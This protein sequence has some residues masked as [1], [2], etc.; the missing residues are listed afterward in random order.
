[1]TTHNRTSVACAVIDSLIKNLKYPKLKWCISDDRSE[2]GHVEA[3]TKQF[4]L[5]GIDDVVVTRTNGAKYG[6]GA[7]LNNGLKYAWNNSDIV[8]TTEDDWYIEKDLDIINDVR[9]LLSN[10]DICMIR[11]GTLFVDN[12]KNK[13]WYVN[14]SQYNS[15]FDYVYSRSKN[16]TKMIFNNPIGLRHKRIY[17][18][19]GYYPENVEPDVVERVIS[20]RYNDLTTYG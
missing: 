2:S 17:D 15:L 16:S 7:S 6:L 3:L 10:P 20:D 8:L 19:I 13:P 4:H 18:K 1:M 12:I 5:N 9:V 14:T 11:Y